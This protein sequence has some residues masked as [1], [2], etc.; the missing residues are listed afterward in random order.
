MTQLIPGLLAAGA[1]GGLLGLMYLLAL[2]RTLQRLHTRRLPG[3]WLAGGMALR[4][5]V[6]GAVLF[7]VLQWGDWHHVLAAIAGFTLAR[8]LVAR[9]MVACK[10]PPADQDRRPA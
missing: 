9:R 6:V 2:W 3:L 7:G 5:I 4:I 10:T 1:T 8:W